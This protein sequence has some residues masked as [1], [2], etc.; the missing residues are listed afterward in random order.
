MTATFDKFMFKIYTITVLLAL[1]GVAGFL[2][3][4]FARVGFGGMDPIAFA[5]TGAAIYGLLGFVLVT[6]RLRKFIKTFVTEEIVESAVEEFR[7]DVRGAYTVEDALQAQNLGALKSEAAVK[8]D[9]RRRVE[10][11]AKLAHCV[12]FEVSDRIPT[13]ART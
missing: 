9:L 5:V 8:R 12:G 2:I 7:N 6:R 11:A 4:I 3:V 1:L 13:S 10:K